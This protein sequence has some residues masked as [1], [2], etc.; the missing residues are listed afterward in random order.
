MRNEALYRH[1]NFFI[2]VSCAARCS[3]GGAARPPPGAR[4]AEPDALARDV[5]AR[6]G[7]AQLGLLVT[8]AQRLAARDQLLLVDLTARVHV[9]GAKQR[10]DHVGECVDRAPRVRGEHREVHRAALAEV[11]DGRLRRPVRRRRGRARPRR[12]SARRRPRPARRTGEVLR[13]YQG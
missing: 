12:A 4:G 7:Q 1:Q 2:G 5:E 10:G 11:L 9:E 6:E 3:A 8:R 13:G